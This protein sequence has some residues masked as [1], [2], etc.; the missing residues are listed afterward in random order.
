ML[1]RHQVLL[2]EWLAEHMKLIAKRADM[3]F[4]EMIR[5]MLC[6]GILRTAPEVF[7]NY[8]LKID[9]RLLLALTQEGA[10]PKTSLERKHQLASQLYFEARKVIEIVN[11]NVSKELKNKS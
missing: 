1:S 4:S 3:S 6:D 9:K 5:I 7:P 10:N 11:A 2:T 8:K